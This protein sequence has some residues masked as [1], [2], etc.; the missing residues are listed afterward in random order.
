MAQNTLPRVGRPTANQAASIDDRLLRRVWQLYVAGGYANI[1]YD[2]IAA[3]ERMSKRTIYARYPSKEALFRA[4]V[5][6]RLRRWVS[7][8]RLSTNS[9]FEDPVWA[10][11]ELS[12]A[13]LLTPDA[14]AMI[15]ILRG[16]D[17][18]FPDLADMA[19]QELGIARARLA[20]LLAPNGGSEDEAAQEAAHF[21]IDMLVGRA[22]AAGG[23]GRD[24][25]RSAYH[26]EQLPGILRVVDRLR[27]R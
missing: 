25:E 20:A 15:R 22:V 16:E 5:S 6:L 23:I 10:F 17:S 2:A 21:I 12:L 9:R 18:R 26:A 4:A 8:N 3:A 11:V 13:A 1:S 14:L 7:E 24:E 27:T 19:R